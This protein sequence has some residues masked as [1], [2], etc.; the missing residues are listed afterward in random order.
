MLGNF[1]IWL[2]HNLMGWRFRLPLRFQ[3]HSHCSDQPL[4]N[5]AVLDLVAISFNNPDA[6]IKQ[7]ELIAEHL[8]EPHVYT[9]VDN[10]SK[11]AARVAIAA[12]CKQKG[13]GYVGLPP[14]SFS[15]YSPSMSHGVALNWAYYHFVKPR[16]AAYFGFL[17][18]DILPLKP[19]KLIPALEQQGL[20]GLR[21]E[22]SSKWY[23]WPGYC[24]YSREWAAAKQLDFRPRPGLDTGGGNA[25]WYTADPKTL[26]FAGQTYPQ[27]RNLEFIDG[28]VHVMGSG[29]WKKDYTS[30][31][32][33]QAIAYAKQ[34]LR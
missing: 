29:G 8:A 6:I 23:L 33:P 27:A 3:Q 22:R 21:Q 34:H 24:F 25:R 19:R 10:S 7:A 2:R 11:A 1:R 18:H 31:D 14:N 16:A 20:Y 9:V 13:I 30:V 15:G 12:F 5:R 32:F 28:W 4:R 26:K 17:D